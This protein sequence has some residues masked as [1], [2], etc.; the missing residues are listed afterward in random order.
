MY[1]YTYI[2]YIH[3]YHTMEGIPTF[4]N[5]Q[6]KIVKHFCSIFLSSKFKASLL[7]WQRRWSFNSSWVENTEDLLWYLVMQMICV[8]VFGFAVPTL[9]VGEVSCLADEV[10]W[11]HHASCMETRRF[12]NPC[13]HVQEE[14]EKCIAT[15][16][17]SFIEVQWKSRSSSKQWCHLLTKLNEFV[18]TSLLTKKTKGRFLRG[19]LP[20]SLLKRNPPPNALFLSLSHFHPLGESHHHRHW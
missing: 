6:P 5:W 11:D 17:T 1:K 19:I 12:H 10:D 3:M 13:S 9:I 15:C 8:F 14:N 18:A 16:Y 4:K 2:L 20:S 7:W